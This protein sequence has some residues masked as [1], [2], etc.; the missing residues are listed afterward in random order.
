MP[1]FKDLT[2]PE[3]RSLL[4]DCLISDGANKYVA[5]DTAHTDPNP[6]KTLRDVFGYI[7]E[8]T[9]KEG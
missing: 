8:D 1:K 3:K 2:E 9:I 5:D 7:D 4:I 6:D